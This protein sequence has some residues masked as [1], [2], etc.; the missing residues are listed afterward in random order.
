[1]VCEVTPGPQEVKRLKRQRTEEAREHK[2]LNCDLLVPNLGFRQPI[3]SM[4]L[5]LNEIEER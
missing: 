2:V 1:V 4:T 3:E 5:P